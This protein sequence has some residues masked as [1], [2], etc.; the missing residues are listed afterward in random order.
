MKWMSPPRGSDPDD[1]KTCGN[2]DFTFERQEILSETFIVGDDPEDFDVP[3]ISGDAQGERYD[4]PDLRGLDLG[5]DVIDYNNNSVYK[6]PS[7]YEGEAVYVR[8]AGVGVSASYFS[9]AVYCPRSVYVLTVRDPREEVVESYDAESG[10]WAGSEMVPSSVG[11]DRYHRFL[12]AV[13][14]SRIMHYYVFKRFS[15]VDSAEAFA[16]L[17]LT[18]VRSLPVPV[19]GLSTEDGQEML[20]E[21]VECVDALLTGEEEIGGTADLEIERLLS[22]LYRLSAEDMAYLHTQMGLVGYQQAVQQLYPE[23]QPSPPERKETISMVTAD[24]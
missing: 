19:G 22:E 18:D 4:P 8:E 10:R 14:N 2:C 5:Y 16:N 24:D 6:N 13:L 1:E 23:E 20:D 12:L 9:D 15:S 7:L 21:I 17:R 11:D 3:Y